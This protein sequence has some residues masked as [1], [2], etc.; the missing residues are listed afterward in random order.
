M[1]LPVYIP[2]EE[3]EEK[4]EIDQKR[5]QTFEYTALRQNELN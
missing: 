4:H 2:N 1:H 3:H 5:I